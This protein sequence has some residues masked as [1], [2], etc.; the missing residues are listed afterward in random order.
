MDEGA[1][2]HRTREVQ[3]S[4]H[5]VLMDPEFVWETGLDNEDV[6]RGDDSPCF[7][8]GLPHE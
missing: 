1:E 4:N 6:V 7:K 8:T 2:E 5:L 3:R